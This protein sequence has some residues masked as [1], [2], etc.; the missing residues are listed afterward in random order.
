MAA[1]FNAIDSREKQR[2][3]GVV[4]QRSHQS[5]VFEFTGRFCTE[6]FGHAGEA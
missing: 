6:V 1:Y 2:V 4:K 5:S 3:D